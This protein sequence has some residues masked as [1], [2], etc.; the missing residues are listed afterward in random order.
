MSVGGG[1][2]HTVNLLPLLSSQSGDRTEAANR[3]VA[4]ECQRHPEL[5]QDIAAALTPA[6]AAL[7]GDC[8]EVMTKVAEA[9]PTLILPYVEKLAPLLDHRT[10]RVRW[11]AMHAL[12]LA[13]GLVPRQITRLLPQLQA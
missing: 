5:L 13:A 4:A 7:A 11:E 8:A 2:H 10:T 1:I 6:D 12:A 9:D 3:A